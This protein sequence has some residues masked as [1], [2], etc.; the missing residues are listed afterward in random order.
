MLL[1]IKLLCAVQC[2]AAQGAQDGTCASTVH[3]SSSVLHAIDR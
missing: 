1:V 2:G 3:P